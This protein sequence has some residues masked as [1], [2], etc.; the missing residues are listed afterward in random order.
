MADTETTS[1]V[2]DRLRADVKDAQRA[3]D[4]QRIDTLR[5]ALGAFHNEEIARTDKTHK[6]HAQPLTEEDRYALIEKQIK[7]RNEAAQLY[8]QGGRPELAEK[9]E[10]EAEILKGYMPAQLGD[11]AIRALVAGLISTHG[12]EFRAIMPLA[13]KETKGHAD[14]KRV[15][16]IVREMTA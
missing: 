14:G 8:R 12:K 3:R 6:L 9:E 10:R 1:P 13:A 11:D 16:E 5:I 4:Q 2:E 7:Q 15:S